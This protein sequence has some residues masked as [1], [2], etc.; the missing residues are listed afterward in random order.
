MISA[1]AAARG[2]DFA[3]PAHLAMDRIAPREQPGELI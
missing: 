1:S 3:E 2:V